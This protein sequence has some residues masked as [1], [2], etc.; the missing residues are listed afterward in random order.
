MG[1]PLRLIPILLLAA[2]PLAGESLPTITLEEAIS[3]AKESNIQLEIDSIELEKELRSADAVMQ[4]FMPDISLSAT[5]SASGNF[6]SG[7]QS[8]FRGLDYSINANAA[9]PFEGSMLTDRKTRNLSRESAVLAYEGDE[10]AFEHDV[11]TGYWG[12][13]TADLSAKAA[14]LSYDSALR[15]YNSEKERYENGIID[16]LSLSQAELALYDAEHQFKTLQDSKARLMAEFRTMTGI[17]T[18]FNTEPLPD[19]VLLALPSAEELFSEFSESSIAVRT[20]RNVLASTQNAETRLKLSTY[21]PT[22]RAS[23]GYSYSGE[24]GPDWVYGT[25]G[26]AMNGSVSISLPISSFIPTSSADISIKE[27]GDEVRIAALSLQSEKDDFLALIRSY[28]MN[29]GQAE[30]SLSIAGKRRD[31]AERTNALTEEAFK[32]GL[33]TADDASDT[34]NDLLNAEMDLLSARLEHLL[35]SYSLAYT[36][37][38]PLSELQTRYART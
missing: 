18:D 3:S 19:P 29:I 20:A 27:A 5:V 32:A 21:V 4:T 16:E 38:I 28:V 7:A 9:F 14:E 6:Q 17:E 35:Q 1:T 36:L 37:N 26:N 31:A 23:V 34:R 30:E 12:L 13:A 24:H 8:G 22:I 33:I 10:T 2:L 25:T 11:I 15:Q